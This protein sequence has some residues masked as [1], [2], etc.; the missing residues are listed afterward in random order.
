MPF[1]MERWRV[2][3]VVLLV[4]V[5]AGSAV[6]WII[7]AQPATSPV[8]CAAAD[9]R[10]SAVLDLRSPGVRSAC[11][12]GS[13]FMAALRSEL[14]EDLPDQ[15]DLWLRG[16]DSG[17]TGEALALWREGR[18]VKFPGGPEWSV[19]ADP[20]WSEDPYRNI[21]WMA[22]YH[23]LGWLG[24][25][26]RGYREGDVALGEALGRYVVSWIESNPTV[27]PPSVR[28][29]YNGAVHR[30]TNSIVSYMDVLL[31][32]LDDE[33]LEE[34]L[35]SLH[36][37]G[38]R[39]SSY[40]T[41][42]RLYGHNH[43][44][45]HSLA[46]LNLA[47]SVPVL[48]SAAP[49]QEGA[50]DR[51]HSLLREMV[52]PVDGVST[53][54]SSQ[55]HF[56]AMDLFASARQYLVTS[57]DDYA[58]EDLSLLAEMTTFGALLPDPGGT[59]PAIGDTPFGATDARAM[60]LLREYEEAG[61]SSPEAQFVLSRGRDG[62]R[63]ADATF[64]GGEGYG[65]FRPSYGEE[66][67]WEDDLHLVVDMGPSNR[68]HGHRDAMNVLLAWRG[69]QMLVDTGGPFQYGVPDRQAI[70]S[71][72][73][74]NTVVVDA[75]DYGPGD[76]AIERTLDRQR[77]ALITGV[78]DKTPGVQHRRTVM[79]V[80]PRLVLVI[81]ELSTAGAANRRFDL[82]YHL[83][84][85][86]AVQPDRLGA[87]VSKGRAGLGF[88]VAAGSDASLRIREAETDP[89]FGWVATGNAT[90]EGAPVLDFAQEGAE[91]AWFVTALLPSTA[92]HS[93]RP[94]LQVERNADGF[95]I[96]VRDGGE[97]WGIEVPRSG[98]PTVSR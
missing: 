98:E 36:L 41:E 83:P 37:H 20:D 69:E 26:A 34:V 1:P 33:Q 62:R 82:L 46:L 89:L 45:F 66:G 91:D 74:H 22:G 57:G 14:R 17:D 67:D 49:W 54:Q 6:V 42:E 5:V 38:T 9:P 43:N 15:R 44:L 70:M 52:N 11:E 35:I 61:L 2:V 73:A 90:V 97:R 28:S 51:L 58:A 32:V 21:T 50:T 76:V 78:H 84:P 86:A 64:F 96:E 56:V 92:R 18:L 55:Y 75:M 3:A 19:P 16:P 40:L 7:Q 8:G 93:G 94:D 71:A 10:L 29:W 48:R 59:L 95:L 27:D 12:R 81:D 63:P 23:A 30:R 25:L 87:V 24:A 80:K 72:G 47:R 4:L 53:E 77:Y 79:L 68:V 88:A 65:I 85:G 39:L 31:D 60:A 13:G